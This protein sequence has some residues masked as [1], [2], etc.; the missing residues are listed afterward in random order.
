MMSRKAGFSPLYVM[1][2]PTLL[3]VSNYHCSVQCVKDEQVRESFLDFFELDKGVSGQAI[4]TLI[5]AALA[6]C[7]LNPS[8]VRGQ[9]YDGVSSMSGR[10]RG[11]AAII[12]QKYPLAAYSHCCSHVLNLAVVKACS[13]IQ[14]QNLFSTIWTRFTNILTTTQNASTHIL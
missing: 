10:Y 2:A 8:L 14:V 5:E 13:L 9:A 4:A 7:H 11:C 6:E 1:S 12:Q 3:I